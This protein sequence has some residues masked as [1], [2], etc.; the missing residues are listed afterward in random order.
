MIRRRLLLLAAAGILLFSPAAATAA[1]ASTAAGDIPIAEEFWGGPPANCTSIT[2]STEPP[3]GDSG[4]ATVPAG[5]YWAGP[6][7]MD[8][9]EVGTEQILSDGSVLYGS[10]EYVCEVAVHEEGHLHE[11]VHSLDPASIMYG[12]PGLLTAG[13][14]PGCVEPPPPGPSAEQARRFWH[15]YHRHRHFVRGEALPRPRV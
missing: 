2:F 8:V 5:P 13:I 11:Q 9:V 10:A 4:F 3:A 1:P 7:V 15:R 12:G 6:C 14:V